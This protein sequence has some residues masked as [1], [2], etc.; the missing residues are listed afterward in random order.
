MWGLSPTDNNAQ[1]DA[2]KAQYGV[3]NPCAGTEGGGPEAIDIVTDGQNFLGY[4]T[5]CIVCPDRTL[6]FD[7][8]WP[9]TVTCFDPYIEQCQPPLGAAF[10][11]MTPDICINQSVTF[12]D[13]SSGNVTSWSWEFEGGDPATSSEENPTVTYTS[14]GY[15]DVTLTVSDGTDS[16]S[17]TQDDYIY[18][19]PCTGVAEIT[20]ASIRIYPNPAH[21]EFSLNIKHTGMVN[22][23]IHNKLG[24]E[25]FSQE[26]YIDN[27]LNETIDLSE[28]AEGLYFVTIKTENNTH[29]RK[30]ILLD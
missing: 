1:I 25:V 10:T 26:N 6:Y 28:F 18:V 9:P 16:S 24:G 19:D 14:T 2:Y 4:P 15:F 27:E 20:D 29:M 17:V 21:G 12:V 8:C 30:L 23:T 7:V 3:T 5:Y 22:I 11:T 13:Q